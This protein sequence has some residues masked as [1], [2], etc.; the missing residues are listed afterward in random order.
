[1][2]LIH[3]NLRVLMAERGLNIQKV[4]DRTSLSRTTISNLYNNFGSGIQYGTLLELCELLKCQPGDLL[5]YIEIDPEFEVLTK[6]PDVTMEEDT[7]IA[8]EEGNGYTFVSSIQT[9][10]DI[11]CKLKYEGNTYEFSF[12]VEVKYGIDEKKEMIHFTSGVSPIFDYKLYD[13]NLIPHAESYMYDSLDDFLMVWAHDF[14]YGN[15]IEGMSTVTMERY[16]L[17]E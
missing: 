8:D 9:S 10:L 14:F 13:L 12:P 16:T 5:T 6:N 1:M 2:G 7:Y 15:E 17:L 11:S 4:K 3:C